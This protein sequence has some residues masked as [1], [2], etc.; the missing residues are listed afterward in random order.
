MTR[1]DPKIH[2]RRSIR[3]KGYD[4]SQAGFYFIT[5]VAHDRVHRFGEIKDEEMLLNKYGAIAGAEWE[6]T[7]TIREDV[8][9]D[10]LVVMPNHVHGIIQI[11]KPAGAVIAD[12]EP[13]KTTSHLVRAR[14]DLVSEGA[15]SVVRANCNSPQRRPQLLKNTQLQS[16]SQTIGAIIRGYKGAVTK[17]IHDMTKRYDESTW[18]RNYYEHIIRDES[19]YERIFEYILNNP[20]KW[21]HDK[22]YS[23]NLEINKTQK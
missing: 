7:E 9:V 2:H 16:P 12:D 23:A 22:Y 1:Y 14:G 17:R 20:A 8:K 5:L 3:L 19:D 10:A 15:P 18:Q 4:Y 21:E 13:S 6:K 11:V